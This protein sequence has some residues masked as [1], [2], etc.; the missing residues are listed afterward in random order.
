VLSLCNPLTPPEDFKASPRQVSVAPAA[1]GRIFAAAVPPQ[2]GQAGATDSA[3]FY[4]PNA[5]QVLKTLCLG[6]AAPSSCSNA[7]TM[8][9]GT[10][11]ARTVWGVIPAAGPN[12]LRLYNT[13]TVTID[14]SR[15]LS[16]Q[17]SA[18]PPV[19]IDMSNVACPAGA[20]APIPIG[21]FMHLTISSTQLAEKFIFDPG[22]VAVVP[23]DTILLLAVHLIRKETSGWSF[24]T[25]WWQQDI[26]K[27]ANPCNSAVTLCSSA[28]SMWSHY[29]MDTVESPASPTATIRPVFNPY[30]EGNMLNS[31]RTNCSVCHSY[32]A[33][34]LTPPSISKL[35]T[36]AFGAAG[37]ITQQ[38]NQINVA[39]FFQLAG[40]Q[41]TDS[42]WT[43]AK[44]L[45]P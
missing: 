16:G 4:D 18:F 15:P 44:T 7:I 22:Q 1:P 5:A 31:S 8:P 35:V 19:P 37:P 26:E 30:L 12:A 20:A 34:P 32:P 29:A 17:S 28:G 10:T 11:I 14:P 6:G 39:S 25:F 9:V 33:I 42:L 38:Q 2:R 36:P 23:G 21:C 40:R 27:A 43:V 3:T 45:S 41:G 24:S 13:A